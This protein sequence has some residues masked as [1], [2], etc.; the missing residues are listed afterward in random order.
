MKRY[1]PDF[2]GNNSIK[3]RLSGDVE[4]GRVSHAFIFEGECGCGRHTLALQLAAAIS[5][6]NRSGEKIPCGECPTCKKIFSG[7]SPDVI[8]LGLTGDKVTI[9]VDTARFIKSDIHVAPNDLSI[10]M[11]IIEDADKMTIQAQNAL[12][13]SLEEPP[14]YVIFVLLCNDSTA[15]L[16]TIKSRAP[17][18]RLDKLHPDEITKYL[19]DKHSKANELFRENNEEFNELVVA[20]GGTIGR[21]IDLLDDKERK[22]ELS[23][24]AIAKSFI[25]LSLNRSKAKIFDM[26]S[27]LGTKRPDISARLTL[28][29]YAI[30][31]LILLKKSDSAALVFYSNRD[32]ASE[33]SAKLTLKRLIDMYSAIGEAIDDLKGS[34]N[35]RLT[36]LSMVYSCGLCD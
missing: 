21:A 4:G 35:V 28:I 5:C 9:G 36:L 15:F 30:R 6:K 31:D 18:Y 1:F 3:H 11:Y 2:Y 17:I 22:K 26:I 8:N 23:E 19:L 10:K 20:S 34:A 25:E 29:Q 24:R 12:L 13:L 14:Q 32:E 7:K 33:I 27:S 16:E